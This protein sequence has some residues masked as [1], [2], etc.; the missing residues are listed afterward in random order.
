MRLDGID[1]WDALACICSLDIC[2]WSCF[3]VLLHDFSSYFIIS[4]TIAHYGFF[5]ILKII[6]YSLVD[7]AI[8]ISH[9]KDV[10]NRINRSNHYRHFP[11][12]SHFHYNSN[13]TGLALVQ[14]NSK[15][16]TF[17]AINIRL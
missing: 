10:I 17:S 7:I 8:I 12:F 1:L 4:A 2:F 13:I 6:S 15:P 14:I 5:I 16:K 9:K 11:N 3:S